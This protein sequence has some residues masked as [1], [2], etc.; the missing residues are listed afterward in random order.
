M[1][2]TDWQAAHADRVLSAEAAA[3]LVRHGDHVFV[4]TACATPRTLVRALENLPMRQGDVQLLHFLTDGAL[5]HDAAG[6]CTSAY[7]HRSFFVGNDVRAAVRQGLCEYVPLSA[8]RL[9]QL[10]AN[11]RVRVDVALIQVSP[12]DPYGYVSLGVSVDV[13]AAA[14]ARARLVLAEVNPAMPRSMGDSTLHVSEIDHLVPVATPVIEYRH[15]E[16]AGDV[17]QAIARYID[18]IIDDGS[19]LQVGL[20]RFSNAALTLMEDRRDLGVHSDVITDAIIPL[21]E[22][23]ILTGRAKTHQRGRIVTSFAMG[24]RRLYDLIDRNP[25][26]DFQPLDAVCDPAVLA[27]QHKLVSVTQAFAIDLTGQVCVDQQDGR[28]YGGLAAQAEFLQGASRSPG[29]K[30]IICLASTSPDGAHSQVR[31]AL[32]EGEAAT[33]ARSDVHYVITEYGIAYLFGKSVRERALALIELAHPRFRAELLR[34]AQAHGW[35]PADQQLRNLQAYPVAEE[36]QLTLKDGRAVLLRP[37]ISTDDVHVRAL[38]H[39]LP[40]ADV[41]TRFFRKVKGLS[42]RDAQRLCNLNRETEVA[43]VAV[44]G[45]REQSEVV[46][47]A[48]YFVD[49]ATHI[50]ETAFMVHPR[51]QGSGL[52]AAL[53][54]RMAEHARARG[55]QGFVA[56]IMA[57]NTKMIRLARAGGPNVSLESEGSTVRVT[58][59]F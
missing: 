13:V 58:T 17:V 36:R 7:R 29:G 30:A 42:N 18:S 38:F 9:P 37:A 59:R 31:V 54:Q 23:G 52:G 34:E 41:Y 2:A 21:L 16:V 24:S 49:A 25:L 26:F 12:P 40:D 5:P 57:S 48:C 56:E 22:K 19:T 14:C 51:W 6:D 35:V 8:A 15:P 46:A 44:V 4:G 33:I 3:G 32:K 27:S 20:G 43:F 10:M 45:P 39:E 1:T 47:H 28:F 11:G 53:Q 50:A 55:V